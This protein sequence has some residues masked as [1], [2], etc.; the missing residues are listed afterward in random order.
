MRGCGDTAGS[1]GQSLPGDTAPAGTAGTA[2][3]PHQNILFG[4][5]ITK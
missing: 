2:P 4:L 3:V 1:V 5:L